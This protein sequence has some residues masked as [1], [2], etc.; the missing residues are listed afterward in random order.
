MACVI[1]GGGSCRFSCCSFGVRV[2]GWVDV[3]VDVDV[4]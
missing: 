4:R 3:D 1:E 2:G